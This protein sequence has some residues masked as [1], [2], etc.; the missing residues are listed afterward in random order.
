MKSPILVSSAVQAL[1]AKLSL[2]QILSWGGPVATFRW[3]FAFDV[4]F[5]TSV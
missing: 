2:D 1:N 4:D 3:D 5:K